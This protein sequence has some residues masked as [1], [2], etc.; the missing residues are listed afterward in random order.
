M[1]SLFQPLRVL[2]Y[3]GMRQLFP[4]KRSRL[5]LQCYSSNRTPR[6]AA[7]V[8][9]LLSFALVHLAPPL[10]YTN[11]GPNAGLR[12]R[13]PKDRS[14]ENKRTTSKTTNNGT[15][16]EPHRRGPL[17]MRSSDKR[18]HVASVSFRQKPESDKRLR[19]RPIHRR[20]GSPFI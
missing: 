18:I 16:D 20:R 17:G 13:K 12:R 1:A 6:Q 19:R 14:R 9:P 15:V 11:A 2:I 7:A 5:P 8:R 4:S 10:T 3:R